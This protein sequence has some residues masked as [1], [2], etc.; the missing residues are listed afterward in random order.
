M[1]IR[2]CSAAI[3]LALSYSLCGAPATGSL[4]ILV[5]AYRESPSPVRGAAIVS[6][7]G[8][9]PKDAALANV[10]LGIEADEQKNSPAA[11]AGQKPLEA[12]LAPVPRLARAA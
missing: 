4:A 11:T 1:T 5:R 9:H 7:A 8:R 2:P 12:N 6:Y 10:A 3:I